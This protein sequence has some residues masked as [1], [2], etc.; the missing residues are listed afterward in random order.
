MFCA[1]HGTKKKRGGVL[2]DH[3]IIY[4]QSIKTTALLSSTNIVN[5]AWALKVLQVKWK[6]REKR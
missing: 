5:L 3:L 1:H 2:I 6:D 4:M